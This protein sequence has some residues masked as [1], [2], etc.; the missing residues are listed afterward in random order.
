MIRFK[1]RCTAF[2]LSHYDMMAHGET[3]EVCHSGMVEDCPEIKLRYNPDGKDFGAD[4]KTAWRA[5]CLERRAEYLKWLELHAD[6]KPYAPE[7]A[8]I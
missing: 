6:C 8:T 4:E 1:F 7:L 2:G 3:R 5:Y